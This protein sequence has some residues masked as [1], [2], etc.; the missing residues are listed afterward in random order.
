MM[1]DIEESNKAN[2]TENY[3]FNH[4]VTPAKIFHHG[5]YSLAYPNYYYY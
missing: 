3:F 5:L 2:E 4:S 1:N